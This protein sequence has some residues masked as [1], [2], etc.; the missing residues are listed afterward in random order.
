MHSKL[1]AR[2]FVVPSTTSADAVHRGAVHNVYRG[3][4]LH[5]AQKPATLIKQEDGTTLPAPRQQQQQRGLAAA[6]QLANTQQQVSS[7]RAI[8]QHKDAA[9]SMPFLLCSEY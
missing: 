7:R 2:G 8:W 5:I 4:A 3:G 6:A 1:T 9:C